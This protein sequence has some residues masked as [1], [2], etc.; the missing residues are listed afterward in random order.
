[1]HGTVAGAQALRDVRSI[2]GSGLWEAYPEHRTARE[3]ERLSPYRSFGG[4][5]F[6]TAA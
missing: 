5:H 3:T 1:M 6:T 4:Q 2:D